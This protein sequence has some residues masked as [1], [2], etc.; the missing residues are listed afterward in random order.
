MPPEVARS[1]R[2]KRWLAALATTLACVAAIGY[3]LREGLAEW[4]AIRANEQVRAWEGGAPI[5]PAGFGSALTSI[6]HAIRLSPANGDH[7][8]SLGT[9][10]FARATAPR[11]T[12]EGRLADFDRAVQAYREATERSMVSGYAWGNLMLAKHYAGQIDEEFS[13]ALRNAARYAPHEAAV[14]TMILGAVLPRWTQLDSAA[15]REAASAAARGW[16]EHRVALVAEARGAGNRE[17]WC[18]S[19]LWPA[20]PTLAEAMRALCVASAVPVKSG[21]GELV[22]AP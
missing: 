18:D 22:R 8:E 19:G 21:A 12:L 13:V 10:W 11:R 17:L 15:R 14:Q 3:V 9:L 7:R 2:L 5:T 6:E 20:E 16:N 4:H 1:T